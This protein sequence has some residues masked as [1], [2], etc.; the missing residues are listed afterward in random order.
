MA[1][2]KK[3]IKDEEHPIEAVR[4]LRDAYFSKF[5]YNLDRAYEDIK[6]TQ[7]KYSQKLI[8]I[9]ALRKGKKV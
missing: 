9:H 1:Q 3:I 5:N 8:D 4:R 6:K 7:E 2:K